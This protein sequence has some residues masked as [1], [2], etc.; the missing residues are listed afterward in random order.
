M[1]FFLLVYRILKN[2]VTFKAFAPHWKRS[3]VNIDTNKKYFIPLSRPWYVQAT[4]SA[5]L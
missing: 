4:G 5:G 2:K 1:I 3:T